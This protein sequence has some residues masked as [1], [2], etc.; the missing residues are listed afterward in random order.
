MAIQVS[1]K[2]TSSVVLSLQATDL[3]DSL[4]LANCLIAFTEIIMG[5][6]FA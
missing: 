1:Q 5:D 3:I 6:L 2:E 4:Q